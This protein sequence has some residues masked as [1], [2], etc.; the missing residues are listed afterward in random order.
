[1]T[2]YNK[3]GFR[4]ECWRFGVSF[5]CANAIEGYKLLFWGGFSAE[6]FN[7]WWQI[8]PEKSKISIDAVYCHSAAEWLKHYRGHS[9]EEPESSR[10]E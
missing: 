10:T 2:L 6:W 9:P 8:D 1:M 5:H 7:L 4:W 3:D